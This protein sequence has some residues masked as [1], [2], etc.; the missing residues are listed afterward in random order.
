MIAL[1]CVRPI[2]YSWFILRRLCNYTSVHLFLSGF[3]GPEEYLRDFSFFLVTGRCPSRETQVGVQRGRSW[4]KSKLN[5]PKRSEGS[6]LPWGHASRPE[7]AGWS[8]L[9]VVDSEES[10]SPSLA[11]RLPPLAPSR[12][13]WPPA[14]QPRPVCHWCERDQQESGGGYLMW[15]EGSLGGG[16]KKGSLRATSPALSAPSHGIFGNGGGGEGDVG[17]SL[18]EIYLILTEYPISY[19]SQLGVREENPIPRGLQSEHHSLPSIPLEVG[20]S[21][22]ACTIPRARGCGH[23]VSWP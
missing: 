3:S 19:H 18:E 12:T 6:S 7:A 5:E 14:P 1:G 2:S 21:Y 8:R 15:K 20:H 9:Y 13:A 23:L 10:F 11:W 22:S 4:S 17:S 16:Q